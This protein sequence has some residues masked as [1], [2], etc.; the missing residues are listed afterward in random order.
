MLKLTR[1]QQ[2]FLSRFLDIYQEM[3]RPIHYVEVSKR[4]NV[5]HV[6]AYEMLRLLEERGLVQSEFRLPE[7]KR[8]PGRAMVFFSP[9]RQA[10]Q[11]LKEMA[12]DA[13]NREDWDQIKKQVLERL[14]QGK[15]AG[16]ETLLNDLLA[17]LPEKNNP[18]LYMAEMTTALLLALRTYLEGPHSQVIREKLKRIGLSGEIG[19]SALAG[20]GM[21]VSVMEHVNR[22]V[23]TFLLVESDKY[24]RIFGELTEE[25][26]RRLG[27]LAQEI[28]Q[29]IQE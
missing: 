1:R 21:V 14:R 5:G 24:Q 19:L 27:N 12:G 18:L 2:E 13:I 15:V 16:Y 8:G 20:M 22:R 7:G 17:R 6:T 26:R 28:Y 9:T 4:L 23:A 10:E 29:I 25:N 3:D 11:A